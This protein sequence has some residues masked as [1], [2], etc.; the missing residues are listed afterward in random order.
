[1][2]LKFKVI[3]S[4]F[5]AILGVSSDIVRRRKGSVAPA[6]AQIGSRAFPHITKS[7]FDFG[8]SPAPAST[9]TRR[10]NCYIP[11]IFASK[12]SPITELTSTMSDQL[13]VKDA[14]RVDESSFPYIFEENVA[15]P[16]KTSSGGI[17]RCNVYRPKATKEGTKLPVLVTKSKFLPR[18]APIAER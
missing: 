8:A 2:V 11:D 13:E 12:R 7:H 17:I 16:L 3:K 5:V 1:M 6:L 14:Y 15:V 9:T 18:T 10:S 4:Q